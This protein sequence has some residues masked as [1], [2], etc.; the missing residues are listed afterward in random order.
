MYKAR[1]RQ[2]TPATSTRASTPA[3][4][5]AA[6]KQRMA[7][8]GGRPVGRNQQ[9]TPTAT[10]RRENTLADDI[11]S[12]NGRQDE[13]ET[14]RG[15]VI[16]EGEMKEQRI[17]SLHGPC[18][19]NLAAAWYDPEERKIQILEDT[20]DTMSWDL[21]VLLLEQIRPTLVIMSSKSHTSLIEKVDLYREENE[22]ELLLLPSRSCYP[23]SASISLASIRL[24]DPSRSPIVA[25]DTADQTEYDGEGFSARG[26]WKE[27]GAGM[28]AYRLN[29]VKLGCWVNVNAPLAIVAAGVLVE[30]I[31]KCRAMEIM[32]GEEYFSGL[33]LT[34]LESMDLEMHMQINKDALTSLAIFDV[35]SHGF[36]YSDKEKQALSVFGK[37]DSSV[38]PLGRKLL[39]TWH[40]RPLLS[41]DEI[42]HRHDA[43]ALFSATENEYVVSS[44]RKI[45]KGVRNV[46][47][48]VTRLQSGRGS[49]VEWKCLVDALT[50]ALEIRGVV[51]ELSTSSLIPIV[52]KVRHVIT[53]DLVVFCQDMNA[54]IDWDTSRLEGRVAVRPGIDEELDEWREVYAG[55]D[56]TLNQV[57][58][59]ISPQVPPGISHSINVV[60][61]PQ[62]GYLAVIQAETEET[63]EI[64]GWE[65]RFHTEDRFY[66][67][68]REM[69][70]LDDHFGDLVTLMIGKE[71]EIV[72][73]LTEYLKEYEP[74][75]LSTV[76]VIAELDCILALSKAARDY[77]LKRPTM[78]ND[79]VLKI[80]KGR[81]ILYESLV[82]HYVENDTV[83]AAGGRD[84]LASMMLITGANGSGKSA[85][86]K[87][88]ALM[89]FMAQIGSFVPAEEAVIGICD[90]IFTRLQTRE[91]SS[92]PASAFMIDLGQISQALRGVTER[93]L[94]VI[95][96]FGK[97][98][99]PSDGAGL[100]AGTIEFL[101]RGVCPRSVVMT[102]FHE[103]FA[104]KIIK[105]EA[106]PV[107]FCHMKTM[108]LEGTDHLEYL[109][110]LVPSMDLSSNAAECALRHGIPPNIVAR[111]KTVTDH[112]S[113]FDISSLLD[114]TLTSQNLLEITASEELAKKFLV[115]KIDPEEGGEEGVMDV[116][117]GMIEET[118]RVMERTETGAGTG[119][120][121]GS[122]IGFGDETEE[123]GDSED[124]TI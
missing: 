120:E 103:L 21:A 68:T 58:R 115:W 19:G 74:S 108:V 83:I 7:S 8:G 16:L 31:K 38:T 13:S 107:K 84:D 90:K 12:V 62:L 95:D 109:Y 54:V 47:A 80:R 20:K 50:A 64:P 15:D 112:I 116:L 14:E 78:S 48:R 10:S 119:A 41:L 63:P 44:L 96:E 4:S 9:P 104:N 123:E 73:R 32:P 69:E 92:R 60:Y 22:A 106:Y 35:E 45:M 122:E 46:P 66:Y 39:H 59:M 43:V 28:G 51:C 91:S 34:A 57:A 3:E 113:R 55:L 23:K 76:E 6:K 30:Q 65:K 94:V 26:E 49:Y 17:L 79:P 89:A 124:E 72:Q 111:A 101:L 85:Y 98:T 118:E 70:D 52:D 18:G 100:L 82:P 114:A 117:K 102:H 33:E 93:S 56:A 25:P 88:V 37:L 121:V 1:K 27:A 71:I 40:L 36:M 86:G 29:M 75:I 61:L 87:Q 42:A 67:K 5:V 105:E 2:A 77:G 11:D 53:D 24:P 97:G 99:I 81:H 110:K